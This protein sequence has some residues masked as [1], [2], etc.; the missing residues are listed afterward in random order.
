[1]NRLKRLPS[2]FA[3]P[4]LIS[5]LFVGVLTLVTSAL[6]FLSR[7]PLPITGLV[8]GC[9]MLTVWG[10]LLR[11]KVGLQAESHLAELVARDEIVNS[12]Q[13]KLQQ[14]DRKQRLIAN[15]IHDGFIQEALAAQMFLEALSTRFDT[16]DE[17]A[18]T[19]LNQA[20]GLLGRSIAE[21]RQLITNVRSPAVDELGLVQ[22]IQSL[23]RAEEDRYGISV[24]F[25]FERDFPKLPLSSQRA[26]YRV[27]QEALSNSRRHSGA[28]E[29]S[30][31]LC[32]DRGTA[33]LEVTDFGCGF[34]VRNVGDQS[35][36]LQGITERISILHGETKIE[37]VPGYGT[38]I[39]AKIPFD[40]TAADCRSA[41]SGSETSLHDMPF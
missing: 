15:E 36:G 7:V 10:S 20:I 33:V 21:G 12:L 5:G 29:I 27:L 4:I 31:K 16:Y 37:S 17:T 25:S 3:L 24:S 13:S 32:S 22:A 41:S 40:D 35:F 19:Q 30:I 14:S 18:R 9:F 11:R 23:V 28:D 6:P 39:V 2:F 1:M 26:L 38:K 8:I 34:N